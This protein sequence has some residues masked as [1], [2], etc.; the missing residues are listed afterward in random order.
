MTAEQ[1]IEDYKAQIKTI[2]DSFEVEA[3]KRLILYLAAFVIKE[4]LDAQAELRKEIYA[5]ME[6]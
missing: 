2:M 6:E 5:T 1:T 3:P 4:R